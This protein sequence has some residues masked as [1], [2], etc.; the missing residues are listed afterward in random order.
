M[1]FI[2]CT[3]V[4]VWVC[5]VCDWFIVACCLVVVWLLLFV[6]MLVA[7]LRV[8]SL[9][10][11]WFCFYGSIDALWCYNCETRLILFG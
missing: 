8:V 3:F 5:G 11:A 10:A 9:Y 4:C 2:C 1:G 6:V 7:L